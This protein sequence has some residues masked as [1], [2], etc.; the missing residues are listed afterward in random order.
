M[1]LRWIGHN[2]ECRSDDYVGR[3]VSKT[4]LPGKRNKKDKEVLGFGEEGHTGGR[5][6][7]R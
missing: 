1:G 3:E 4:Y 7:G 5:S 2:M 6:E